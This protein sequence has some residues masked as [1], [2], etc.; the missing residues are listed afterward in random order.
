[1]KCTCNNHN[2]PFYSPVSPCQSCP[3]RVDG[4]VVFGAP[5]QLTGLRNPVRH[6]EFWG[7]LQSCLHREFPQPA[8]G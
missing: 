4:D 2:L 1:M 7:Y 8:A 5:L 3:K 6:V